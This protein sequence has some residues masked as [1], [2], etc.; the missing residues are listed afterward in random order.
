M[1]QFERIYVHQNISI[2][3]NPSFTVT[4]WFAEIMHK[5]P[6]SSRLIVLT[7]LFEGLITI[8][9]VAVIKHLKEHRSNR[10]ANNIVCGQTFYR[11]SDVPRH[12]DILECTKAIRKKKR[13]VLVVPQES[14]SRAHQLL[15]IRNLQNKLPVFDFE[16]ILS[17]SLILEAV[18]R[19]QS[20]FGLWR[21]LIMEYNYHSAGTTRPL[22]TLNWKPFK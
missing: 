8:G 9:R 12:S 1:I 15:K 10:L 3:P 20:I 14:L 4:R 21:A 22:I 6:Q 16:N 13:S 2:S 18:K 19:H 11:I 7:G 5:T 17:A